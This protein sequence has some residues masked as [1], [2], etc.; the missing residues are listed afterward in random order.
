MGQFAQLAYSETLQEL[1][2][3]F[4][5]FQMHITKWDLHIL[6]KVSQ[7]DVRKVIG[8]LTGAEEADKVS[9]H[10]FLVALALSNPFLNPV[11]RIF[12][13]IESSCFQCEP[14]KVQIEE[15]KY[16]LEVAWGFFARVTDVED[17]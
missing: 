15:V 9:T 10:S 5:Q 1:K 16:L 11:D 4:N 13:A 3:R 8:G 6:M 14:G 2:Q 7:N 12:D 17:A